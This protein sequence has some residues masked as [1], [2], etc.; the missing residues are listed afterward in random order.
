MCGGGDGHGV[1]A[2]EV[3][4]LTDPR[5]PPGSMG[6]RIVELWL[7]HSK[8]GFSRYLDCAGT[9]QGVKLR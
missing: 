5:E 2:N 3:C 7:E 4:V 6:H 8:T 1:L 9:T